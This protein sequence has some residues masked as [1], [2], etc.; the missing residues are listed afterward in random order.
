MRP[1]H[2][3]CIRQNLVI[4][5]VEAAVIRQFRKPD[6]SYRPLTARF[7]GVA[8]IGKEFV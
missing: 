3:R 6:F 8:A 1:V 5:A 7:A 2:S 4:Q